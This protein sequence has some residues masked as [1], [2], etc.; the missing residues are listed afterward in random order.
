MA[1]GS[2]Y[3][4]EVCKLLS[5]WWT[6][7]E[8]DDVFW[9]SSNSGGRATMRGK[10][11]KRTAGSYGDIAATDPI[12]KPLLDLFTIELKRG[13]NRST[14]GDLIDRGRQAPSGVELFL[15]QAMTA[16][17]HAGSKTWMLIHRRDMRQALV[18]LPW[19]SLMRLTSDTLLHS[20]MRAD[21]TVRRKKAERICSIA[22]L[23]LATFLNAVTPGKIRLLM[24]SAA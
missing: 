12:G 4:R 16:A 23:P 24:A 13:Y 20:L 14:I 2:S 8:R 1:K 11:G 22:V 10:S 3:E 19:R 9:R 7:G 5:K 6:N 15:D 18:Y 17:E 21:V